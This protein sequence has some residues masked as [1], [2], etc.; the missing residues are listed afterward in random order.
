MVMRLGGP[1][2]RP[3]ELQRATQLGLQTVL[4]M[5]LLTVLP[6]GWQMA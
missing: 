3:R 6:W 5:A 4:Q 2:V 1:T